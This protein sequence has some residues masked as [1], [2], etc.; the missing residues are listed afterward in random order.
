MTII[1]PASV[2][3]H[4]HTSQADDQQCGRQIPALAPGDIVH[5]HHHQ[6]AISTFAIPC[7]DRRSDM[8][9][10]S[11]DGTFPDS[12]MISRGSGKQAFG[13][14]LGSPYRI[15][16]SRSTRMSFYPEGADSDVIYSPL[17]QTFGVNFP[18]GYLKNLVADCK[19]DSGFHP[20][21]FQTDPLIIHLASAIRSEIESPGF[22]SGLLIDGI[23]KAMAI[24]LLAIDHH[25]LCAKTDRIRLPIWKIR[26][27]T[28]YIEG[29]LDAD[30][31]LSDLA[32]IAGLSAFHFGRVFKQATG[33]S[34]YHFLRD[35]RIE[36]SRALLVENNLD[37][38]QVALLC[39]FSSQSHF[40]AAFTKAVGTSPARYRRNGLATRSG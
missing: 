38:A 12:I 4:A 29:N 25:P 36:R 19:S 5:I 1:N 35:R 24:R 31:R 8:M 23:S 28:D 10:A 21:L 22:A 26:R 34:P 18:S 40:T 13:K 6:T 20:I 3:T 14:I 16:P 15:D 32:N 33:I 7:A 39:G 11:R 30:I 37:I 2:G 17:G 9:I 27:I